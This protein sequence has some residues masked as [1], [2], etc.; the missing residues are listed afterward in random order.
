MDLVTLD[1]E[2]YL[3]YFERFRDG[4]EL[5]LKPG[6]RIFYG[7]GASQYDRNNKAEDSQDGPL[8]LN[9]GKYGSSGRRKWCFVDW[10]QDGD[11]DILV[12]SK[13][14]ALFENVGT[15]DGKVR[16][17]FKGD[18]SDQILAG[19]TTSPTIVDWDRNGVPDLLLGAEDGFL[20]YWRND[21]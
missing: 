18:L 2:G 3:A 9:T 6:E 19:H 8:R 14:V 4:I 10:D 15:E 17:L 1:H 7:V 5:K 20:Y 16:M 11:L 21:R 12:N 13:N